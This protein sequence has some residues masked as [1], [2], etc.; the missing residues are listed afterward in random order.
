MDS[1]D[2]EEEEMTE[3]ANDDESLATDNEPRRDNIGGLCG[4][5]PR[6]LQSR[7]SF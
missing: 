7:A 6:A 3:V 1:Q 2:T 4:R 5:S